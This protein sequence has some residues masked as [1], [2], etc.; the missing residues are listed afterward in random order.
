MGNPTPQAQLQS[1][2]LIVDIVPSPERINMNFTGLSILVDPATNETFEVGME[3]KEF[4]FHLGEAVKALML[5]PPQPASLIQAAP[6]GT[7]ILH[8]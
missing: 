2:R 5:N 4:R 7:R 8:N 3:D 6:P 1:F